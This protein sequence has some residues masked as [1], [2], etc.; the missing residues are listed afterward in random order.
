MI[1]VF[2]SSSPFVSVALLSLGGEPLGVESR[3]AARNADEVLP[4]LLDE[5]KSRHTGAIERLVADVGPGSFTGTRVGVAWVK[6]MG[7]ALGLPVGSIAAWQL[8]E[9]VG[10]VA[11]P[12]KKGEWLIF[13]GGV[14][15]ISHDLPSEPF[16]GF[17][18]GIENPIYPDASRCP[19]ADVQWTTPVEILPIYAVGPSISVPKK[20]FSTGVSG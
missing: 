7:H 3:E 12:L 2:S 13:R 9:P 1:A 16:S 19:V 11:Y 8:I 6:A 4:E 15:E 17:G 18:P 5:L 14:M 10:V 20:P